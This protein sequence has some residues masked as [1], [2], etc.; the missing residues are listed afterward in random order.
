MALDVRLCS[1][2]PIEMRDRA[3]GVMREPGRAARRVDA[4]DRLAAVSFPGRDR[5][6][7]IAIAMLALH[8]AQRL[9]RA[10]GL[11]ERGGRI[12]AT[13]SSR[14]APPVR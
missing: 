7:R 11:R 3:P 5:R 9:R 10:F 4:R 14:S 13:Q 1:A 6:R 8:R 12:G 2:R